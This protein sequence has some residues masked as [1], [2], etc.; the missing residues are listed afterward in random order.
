[1]LKLPMRTTSELELL[2][3]GDTSELQTPTFPIKAS[4]YSIVTF[5]LKKNKS[6]QGSAMLLWEWLG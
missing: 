5:N 6:F 2:Y 3:Y 1:M 4:A